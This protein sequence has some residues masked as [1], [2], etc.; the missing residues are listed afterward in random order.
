VLSTA[1]EQQRLAGLLAGRVEWVTGRPHAVPVPGSPDEDQAAA[2]VFV[3]LRSLRLTDL[4]QGARRFAAELDPAEA[5][6]WRRSWTRTRFL[7]GNPA[8]L[9]SPSPARLVAPCGTAAWLGPFPGNRGPGLS[10]LL[11]PVTGNLP[12]LPS[13]IDLPGTG[14]GRVLCMAVG[15]LTL[16]DYLVHLHHTL[17]EAVL[18]GRLEPNEP[19]RLSHRPALGPDSTCSPPLYARVLPEPGGTGRLRPYT[20]LSSA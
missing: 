5:M 6:T 3:L 4:V 14:P 11:K 7:F 20:W 8:N 12:A 2:V 10:R 1:S 9:G 19:L 15:G 18:L 13:D 17:A 16:V